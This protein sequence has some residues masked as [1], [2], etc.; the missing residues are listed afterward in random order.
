MVQYTEPQ[1][2]ENANGSIT[3]TG[4]TS[5]VGVVGN[6]ITGGGV[7]TSGTATAIT[8]ASNVVRGATSVAVE[9]H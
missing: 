4:S 1:S 2:I 9:T 7:A 6:I 5:G 3:V 8:V